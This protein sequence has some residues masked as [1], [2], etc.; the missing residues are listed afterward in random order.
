MRHRT[1]RLESLARALT[2]RDVQILQ[3]LN[4]S[5]YLVLSQ[6][7]DLYFADVTA[8][9]CSQR[10]RELCERGI[11]G[12]VRH[13]E[14]GSTASKNY[15]HLTTVGVQV[16]AAAVPGTDV[17]YE[18]EADIRISPE[19][20]PHVADV[21]SVRVGLQLRRWVSDLPDYVY[22]AGKRARIE[23]KEP[24]GRVE[25]ITPDVIVTVPMP[26]PDVVWGYFIEIDEGTMTLGALKSKAERYARLLRAFDTRP[27]P[28]RPWLRSRYATAIIAC[29]SDARRQRIRKMFE[30]AG[31]TD[32]PGHSRIWTYSSPSDVPYGIAGSVRE[33]QRKFDEQ[34]REHAEKAAAERQRKEQAL[35][36]AHDESRLAAER[37]R[38]TATR[39]AWAHREYQAQ[40][41][42]KFKPVGHFKT[43]FERR[44]PPPLRPAPVGERV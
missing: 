32:Q 36:R 10:L 16:L 14:P 13:C 38:W 34:E 6:I 24:L 25:R 23:W 26:W 5:R 2:P 29:R 8:D 43:E 21:A 41:L 44:F 15:Y 12:R 31:F 9:R 27:D 35:R 18:T 22:Q 33:G 17:L 42:F 4:I 11:L 30:A 7:Q 40:G 20:L 37:Q 28:A 1:A 19:F 39:D 3:E